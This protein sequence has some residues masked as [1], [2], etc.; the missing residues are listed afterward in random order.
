MRGLF[1]LKGFLSKNLACTLVNR[2][3]SQPIMSFV[4]NDHPTHTLHPTSG[5]AYAPL[6]RKDRYP[7][8]QPYC[9][10]F[11]FSCVPTLNTEFFINLVSSS[12]TPPTAI[13]TCDNHA[14]TLEHQSWG[15]KPQHATT[16]Y[17]PTKTAQ[18]GIENKIIFSHAV[19]M[20]TLMPF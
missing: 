20:T 17:N 10:T 5:I 3:N 19:W 7:T 15:S 18:L 4:T 16:T 2:L 12:M 6:T 11:L 8:A 13:S 14:I 1:H 9:G